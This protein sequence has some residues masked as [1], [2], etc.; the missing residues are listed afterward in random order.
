[1]A[2]EILVK[3]YLD[4]KIKFYDIPYY[5]RCA[6]KKFYQGQRI[7]SEAQIYC[8][9]DEVRRYVVSLIG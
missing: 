3:A 8:V 9:D 4:N 5:I 1:S 6:L 2:N 7:E